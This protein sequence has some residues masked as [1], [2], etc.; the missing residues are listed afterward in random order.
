[1]THGLRFVFG[2]AIDGD[3]RE[4]AVKQCKWSFV[5]S[6]SQLALIHPGDNPTG[7]KMTAWEAWSAYGS[8]VVDEAIENSGAVLRKTKETP[9]S[10]LRNRCSNL[11]ISWSTAAEVAGLSGEEA[12]C[13]EDSSSRVP[14]KTLGAVAFALGLDERFLS[15]REDCGDDSGLAN[16]LS[17]LRQL[18]DGDPDRVSGRATA[19]IAE[20]VSVMRVQNRLQHWLGKSCEATSFRTSDDYG[21]NS[22]AARR[23]GYRLAEHVRNKLGL[24]V[25]RIDSMKDL[26]EGR[27]GIPIVSTELPDAVAGATLSCVDHTGKE[28][29]GVLVNSIGLNQD[30]WVSR[31]TL[32]RELGHALFDSAER[33]EHVKVA[34]HLGGSEDETTGQDVVKQRADAFAL[35]FLAPMEEV[36]RM[37]P[38]PLNRHRVSRIMQHFGMCETAARHRI[39]SCYS[40]DVPNVP[41]ALSSAVPTSQDVQAE[42]LV[43][44]GSLPCTVKESRRGQFAEVV[45]DSYKGSLISEDTAAL[46]LGCSAEDFA[47]SAAEDGV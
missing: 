41:T 4:D 2:S 34:H 33:I 20:C 40:W 27:L 26:V 16:R 10:G 6:R 29:R 9:E 19:A 24:G 45:F 39:A 1:M 5:R 37:A 14:I 44:D 21:G 8:V 46:Y 28:F 31:V 36:K 25:G 47:G 17:T 7:H 15:Y 13:S 18:P 42:N 3:S 32:A 11:G 35:A 38:L 30:V 43:W 22:A 23:T 12:T